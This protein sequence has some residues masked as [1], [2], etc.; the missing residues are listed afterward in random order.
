MELAKLSLQHFVIELDQDRILWLGIDR[1]NEKVNSL[2]REVLEEFEQIV[3]A[4]YADTPLGVVVYSCKTTGF[5]VGADIREFEG[6]SDPA[7]VSANIRQVHASFTRFEKLPCHK[8]AAVEGFCLGGG[9]EVALLCDWRIALDN[10]NTKF[11][12]PEVNLGII[13]GFGGTAR[14]LRLLGGQKAMELMLTGRMLSP[15]PARAMGLIDEVVDR[16]GSLRWAARRAVLKGRKNKGIS[17]VDQLTLTL[18]ARK[19]LAKIMRKT[20]KAKARPEHYPAPYYLIDLYETLGGNFDQVLEGEARG[21]GKLMVGETSRNLR[22]VFNLMESLKA[23]GKADKSTGDWKP[24][25]LHVIGAGV[26]GGDIAAW[27][28]LRGLEVTLQDREM[29][30]IEPAIKRAHKLFAKKLKSSAKV[31]AAKNRLI[32]D[33]E[34]TGAAQADVVIEAIFENLQAKQDLFKALEPKLKPDAVMASNT[35]AIPLEQIAAELSDPARLIGIH[36]FN[37]VAQMPLVEVV[38]GADS[39]PVAVKRGQIFCNA[40]GKFPLPVKSAPGFLV[41]RALAPY[42]LAATKI[43]N[44][45]GTPFAVLDAAAKQFGM[46]MG[47]V[48]LADTVGLDV[49]L[50]VAKNLLPDEVDGIAALQAKVDAKKLGKKNGEGFYVWKEGKPQKDSVTTDKATLAALGS[51]LIQPLLAECEAALAEAVVESADLLDAGIIFGTG[52]APFRGGPLH[53]LKSQQTDSQTA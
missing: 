11:G 39:D 23:L 27:A 30:Y 1:A 38:I 47:P 16:H 18:P 53:Y 4:L 12:F 10:G 40:I 43:H 17:K 8:V 32:A 33:V 14:S 34:G 3:D 45:E 6:M 37:P 2:G 35:S 29:Q 36:F 21:V 28:A 41:N 42:M 52:F 7:E 26:M 5:I 13:P 31:A 22:R 15:R 50:S 19:A 25:R 51:R 20:V 46:P 44:T 24:R 9:L 48:E 49:A